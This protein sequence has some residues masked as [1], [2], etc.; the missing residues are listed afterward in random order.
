MLV[1]AS[2]LASA[3]LVGLEGKARSLEAAWKYVIISSLGVTIALAGTLFLF[4]SASA[5]HLTSNQ[6]LTWPYLLA[7]AA[8]LAP[9][10]LRLAFLLAVVGYG[11]KVGLAPMHTWLPDA[12][13]EA[14][15]P[16]SAMLSA[17]LLNTGMYAIIRFLAITQARLGTAFPHAVLLTFG[18]ASIVIG[19]LFMVRRGNFK[20][21][22][23][24]SSVEH[25]GI[26]AVALGFGGV[27]GLYGALLQTLNHAIAKA[28]L[29]LGSGD[30]AL[31]YRTREAAGVRGLLTAVPVTGGALLLGSLAVLGSPPF[32]LFLSELT[33]V[34]AGFAQVQPGLPAAAAGPARGGVHRVRPD[35]RR[36]G[37]RA[38]GRTRRIRYRRS[39]AR[40]AAS[41]A[42][43]R[44]AGGTAGARPV[45]PGRAEHRDPA[46]GGGDPVTAVRPERA[47]HP[48]PPARRARRRPFRDGGN[49]VTV[50]VPAGQLETAVHH[51]A[52]AGARLADLFAADGDQ[53]TLRLVWALDTERQYLITETGISGGEYPPLSDIAPAAFYEE[54]EIYEQFGIRPAT[55]KPL[56]RVALPPH[57]RAG[58]PAARAPAASRTPEEVHAPH[59]VGGQAFE[60]PFGPV[61]QVGVESLY[62]G[63]VTSGEE[64]VDLYLFTWHKHRGLEWR[65][66][67][68]A[69][70]EA[71]FYAERT[72]GLSAIGVSWAVRRRRGSGAGR[73]PAAGSATHPRRRAGAG[74]AVQPCR[75]DRGAVP[76]VPASRSGSPPPRSRWSGCCGSTRPRSATGI[77]SASWQR[78]GCGGPPTPR[79]SATGCPGLR[80][81]PPRRRRAAV[82]ELLPGPA[83]GDRDHHQRAGPPPRPGRP[84]RPGRRGRRRHPRWTSP[85]RPISGTRPR[86]RSARRRRRAG[87]V[88]GSCWT[89]RPSRSG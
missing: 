51:L 39:G 58:L 13:A 17:A 53:V 20:R 55:G 2:T 32:G 56:N 29:F 52:A 87:P 6:R 30:V 84:G 62:Y 28:V 67:G 5:L 44:R 41:A 50:E 79:P 54:C 35:H 77:C 25:M 60:F 40:W 47:R 18:F 36:H 85:Q 59:T 21:L 69:P 63:L 27:L 8:A 24:Y 74:T 33:I 9:Q 42:A 73:R 71:L 16:A 19:V 31:R 57:A 83:G 65:L 61:R 22:F 75:R 86:W 14:P 70:A 78:A 1:E 82:H 12:H 76:V 15:S 46:L 45:D 37:D 23:A 7:H 64:V 11:T 4:Y 81:A 72:E 49:A 66:R 68:L 10:P 88:S 26:I 3:A 34:R 48:R 38:R 80:R 43:G 89:R